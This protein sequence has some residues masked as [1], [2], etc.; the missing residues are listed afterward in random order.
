MPSAV[1]TLSVPDISCGHCKAAIESAVG[2]LHDVE[3]VDVDVETKTVSV[4]GGT[5]DAVVDAVVGAGY[6]VAR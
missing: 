4:V 6:R 2:E 3:S 5:E 1:L